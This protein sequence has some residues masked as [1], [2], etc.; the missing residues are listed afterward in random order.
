MPEYQKF[1]TYILTSLEL[2]ILYLLKWTL[3]D[4]LLLLY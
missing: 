2:F 3:P 4:L 1:H